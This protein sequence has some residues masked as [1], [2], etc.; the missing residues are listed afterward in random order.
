MAELL[1]AKVDHFIAAKQFVQTDSGKRVTVNSALAG[2]QQIK[3]E[4]HLLEGN[5]K[6]TCAQKF[7]APYLE[8]SKE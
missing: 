3:S 4:F 6:Q 8:E 5:K 2:T 1:L 7:T